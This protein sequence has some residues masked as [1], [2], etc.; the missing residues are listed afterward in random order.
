M[1]RTRRKEYSSRGSWGWGGVRVG[2]GRGTVGMK[3]L[4]ERKRLIDGKGA[5]A[6]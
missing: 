2:R 1:R 5:G 6:E 4:G 3:A